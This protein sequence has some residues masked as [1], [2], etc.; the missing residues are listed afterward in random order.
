VAQASDAA[1]SAGTKGS[2]RGALH[3]VSEQ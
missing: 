3:L 2:R 1:T